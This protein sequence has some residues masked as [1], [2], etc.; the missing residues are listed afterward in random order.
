M[1]LTKI[2]KQIC[3]DFVSSR[4][5]TCKPESQENHRYMKAYAQTGNNR[6]NQIISIC[7][8]LSGQS[9]ITTLSVFHSNYKKGKR[10]SAY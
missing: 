4:V 8:H 1:C 6:W 5:D 3:E 7:G 9:Q 10:S 2:Y